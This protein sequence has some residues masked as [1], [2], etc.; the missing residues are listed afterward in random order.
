MVNPPPKAQD[1]LPEVGLNEIL[2]QTD[3]EKDALDKMLEMFLDPQNISH[4]TELNQ[5]EVT[6]F[7]VLSS[8]AK[9][10]NLPVLRDFLLENLTLRVSKGRKGRGEWVKILGRAMNDNQDEQIRKGWRD[11]VM[12]RRRNG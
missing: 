10:H 4:N 7:S 2:L 6:A 11:R 9:R 5:N 1:A 12:G 8:M 3:E